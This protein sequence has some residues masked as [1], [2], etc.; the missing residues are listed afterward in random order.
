[1]PTLDLPTD[2]WPFLYLVERGIPGVYQWA[3]LAMAVFVALLAGLLHYST[4]HHEHYGRSGM[5]ATKL[6]FVLMGMAFLLLETKSVIQFSLLFGTTWLNSSLVFL[7]V[8]LLGALIVLS[9][10]SAVAPFIYTLF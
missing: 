8:L 10:G 5:L 1:M 9:Q 7:A 2:N 6:A 3:M 4:R